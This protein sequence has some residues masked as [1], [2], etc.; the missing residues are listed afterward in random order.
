MFILGWTPRGLA[1]AS[2]MATA[3][4][5]PRPD[6]SMLWRGPSQRCPSWGRYL[7]GGV[8]KVIIVHLEWGSSSSSNTCRYERSQTSNTFKL[9]KRCA[10][11]QQGPR[12][13]SILVHA[14]PGIGGPKAGLRLRPSGSG[15]VS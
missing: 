15:Y 8:V 7:H 10:W 14:K 2:A 3:L 12:V 11:V 1:T 4:P 5:G 13:A 6:S 9:I